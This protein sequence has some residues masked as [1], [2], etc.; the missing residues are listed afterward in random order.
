MSDQKNTAPI[1][2]TMVTGTMLCAPSTDGGMVEIGR[3]S[4]SSENIFPR[5]KLFLSSVQKRPLDYE[6]YLQMDNKMDLSK[7]CEFCIEICFGLR[8]SGKS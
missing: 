7:L 2:G 3:P 8:K 5:F 1:W 4:V 6:M